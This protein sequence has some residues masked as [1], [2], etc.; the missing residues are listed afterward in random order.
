MLLRSAIGHIQT[1]LK[2]VVVT[3]K[4]ID[5]LDQLSQTEKDLLKEINKRT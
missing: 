2:N 5:S 3:N 4:Y 1:I